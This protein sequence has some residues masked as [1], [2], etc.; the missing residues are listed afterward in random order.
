MRA[1]SAFI[2]V[3]L[4][5]ASSP[6][7]SHPRLV[8]AVPAENAAARGVSLV[9]LTFSER[10]VPTFSGAELSMIGPRAHAVPAR[11]RVAP[12]GRTLVVAP[13][14]ALPKGSYRVDWHVVSTDTHRVKGGYAFRV[15]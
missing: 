7:L 13:S 12:D 5:L 14:R 1:S 6:A 2:A 8:A 11:V 10:L 3:S 9:R 15:G 4:V